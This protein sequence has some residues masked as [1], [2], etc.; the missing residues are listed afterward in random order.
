[1]PGIAKADLTWNSVEA[2]ARELAAFIAENPEA[3]AAE[4]TAFLVKAVAK[5][6]ATPITADPSTAFSP[7][8]EK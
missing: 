4:V 7:I 6:P 8:R 3:S 2:T 1:M 5:T